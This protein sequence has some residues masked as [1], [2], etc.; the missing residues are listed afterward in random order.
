MAWSLLFIF[1]EIAVLRQ[2]VARMNNNRAPR[3]LFLTSFYRV[4]SNRYINDGFGSIVNLPKAKPFVKWAGGKGNLLKQLD[5]FLPTDFA[6]Q[7]DVSY[8]EPFVGGGAMLFHMLQK[9][10]NIQRVVI[11]DINID[12]IRC[13]C[14]IKDN[15]NILIKYLRELQYMY[16]NCSMNERKNFYYE[17]RD[18]FNDGQNITPDYKAALFIFLNRTCFNGLYR[19]NSSGEFNVPHGRYKKPIICN[20]DL[21]ISDHKLLNSIETIICPPGDYSQILEFLG[22]TYNFVYFDPPYRP[23]LNESNFKEYSNSPFGDIQQEELKNFCDELS[24]LNCHIMVS[25][26]DSRN[27]DGSSYFEKL[28]EEYS[29]SKILAPRY[30][31]AIP[32]KRNKLTEVVLTNYNR[33]AQ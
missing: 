9:Y 16:D 30:I 15:P 23:L 10:P 25:N 5:L 31:N 13:Y 11:N 14:L 33:N 3:F 29:F 20:E 2:R 27:P 19:V 12:L 21:I 1:G 7:R 28:Y 32:D 4:H 17:C 8:I 22:D 24:G 6:D 26:S 18:R